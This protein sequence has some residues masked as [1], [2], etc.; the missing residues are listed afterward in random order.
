MNGDVPER[1]LQRQGGEIEHL[2]GKML[3]VA[4]NHIILPLSLPVCIQCLVYN[5]CTLL[6][7][8]LLLED[9]PVRDAHQI[10]TFYLNTSRVGTD[11]TGLVRAHITS[12]NSEMCKT[13]VVLVVILSQ[14][15]VDD[16]AWP[17]ESPALGAG[18]L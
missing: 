2:A 18:E 16:A 7:C 6:R 8:L 15:P 17:A 9:C 12:V 10:H 4:E 3:A 14:V 11:G 5:R 1:R 13:W